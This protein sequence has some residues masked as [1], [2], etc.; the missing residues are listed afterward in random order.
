MPGRAD[1]ATLPSIHLLARRK[2]EGRYAS[3]P[4]V[5]AV[6][7]QIL[8]RVPEGAVVNGI[9]AHT[10][11]IAPVGPVELRACAVCDGF[12]FKGREVAIVG[13]GDTAAEE[14]LYL[15]KLCTNV[16]MFI[17]R[18]QM[19]ASQIMQ[20]RIRESANIKIYWNTEV[21]EILGV[22]PQKVIDLMALMG[23]TVDNIPGAKGI[24]E[25]GA[26]ELIQKYGSVENALDHADEVSNKRYRE[27]LQQQRAQVMMSKQL[28]T[29]ATDVPLE[30]DLR[31]LERREPDVVVLA[32]LYRELGFN[33][34][35]REL[36][37]EAVASSAPADAESTTKADYAQFANVAEFREYLAKLPAKQPV[38]VWLN[39]ETGEREAEGFGTRIDSIEISPIDRAWW[40]DGNA[41]QLLHHILCEY[42]GAEQFQY[43]LGSSVIQWQ[44][45]RC[46]VVRGQQPIE[47]DRFGI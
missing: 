32:T 38:A 47:F 26:T 9:D 45:R 29:I 30:L 11:V 33:S 34:L 5:T 20:Q 24:G 27:A 37:S 21:E 41:H 13:A 7:L 28:A 12:F 39:L 1:L 16:H 25:K 43:C 22:P 19:R 36:G 10:A 14:A 46:V 4:V 40:S 15:S 6:R 42:L 23:D 35:L 17:R 31:A 3:A 44:Y 18:D 2:L 8:R